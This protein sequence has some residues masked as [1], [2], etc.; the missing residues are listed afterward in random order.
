METRGYPGGVNMP[1]RK[2]GAGAL[3]GAIA[4]LVIWSISIFA[5]VQ[6]PAEQ[7]IG[8]SVIL[9]FIVQYYV[10]DAE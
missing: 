6:V 2:V 3:A 1:S 8:L 7:A 4:G 5:G 9:T 10:K